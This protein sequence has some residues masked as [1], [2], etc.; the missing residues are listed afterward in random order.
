M[1]IT[2]LSFILSYFQSGAQASKPFFEFSNMSVRIWVT[3]Y[4]ILLIKH[5]IKYNITFCTSLLF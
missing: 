5:L 2:S 1:F 3:A 4:R